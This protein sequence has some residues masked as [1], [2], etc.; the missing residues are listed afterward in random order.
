MGQRLVRV[1]EL[2]KREI[3]DIIHT[4]YQKEAVCITISN[5]SVAPDLRQAQVNYSVIGNEDQKN[6]AKKFLNQKKVEIRLILGK[7][8]VLKYLPALNF[9]F[10][11]SVEQSY[12]INQLMDDMGLEGE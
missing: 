8:I 5:V 4:R 7:R 1:N 10:D 3:S 6:K 9:H 11:E 2:I 12:R